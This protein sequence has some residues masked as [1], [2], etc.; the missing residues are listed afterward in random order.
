M[1]C[2][3]SL[4]ADCG[5]PLLEAR[6]L[7]THILGVNRAWL[8]AH[9]TDPLPHDK[10]RLFEALAARRREGEPV[11]YLLGEREFMGHR[12]QVSPAVLIPRPE[13]ELLVETALACAHEVLAP[14]ILDMGTG[15]GAISISLAL[16]RPD[17]RVYATDLSEHA[18][19][20]ARANVQLLQAQ[21]TVAQGSWYEALNLGALP[22]LY[23]V[24]VSNPPYISS[25]DRHLS[26]G[27]LRFEPPEALTDFEDGLQALRAIVSG[28]PRHLKPGGCIWLE[29]GW[30][31]A[32][33]V[34][35]LLS[36]AGLHRI[37]SRRDLAGIERI[38]GG[39]L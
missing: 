5:L 26:Q 18:L 7:L 21:V 16:A 4:I 33:A 27:D 36:A 8:I 13:T 19:A 17:A 25:T 31:Q 6:A 37:E 29:H 24:I 1:I 39:Y 28:A 10:V 20:V 11:A 23:D 2:A 38:S 15:S 9:D 35:E 30:D 3:R 22:A 32:P 14:T 34:R 12:L